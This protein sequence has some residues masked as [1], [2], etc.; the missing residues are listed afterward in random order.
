MEERV[1][2][3]IDY[4]G[5]GDGVALLGESGGAGVGLE[6][7]AAGKEAAEGGGDRERAVD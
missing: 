5:G 1:G 2:E 6:G 3:D 4:V 7:G